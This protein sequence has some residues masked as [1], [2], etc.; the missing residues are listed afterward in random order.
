MIF[1]SKK[2]PGI[3]S[4]KFRLFAFLPTVI[5]CST[6]QLRNLIAI[7]FLTIS[8]ALKSQLL[9]TT[10][11]WTKADTEKFMDDWM[12][13]LTNDGNIHDFI[14][15]DSNSVLSY[16]LIDDNIG[17]VYRFQFGITKTQKFIDPS[18]PICIIQEYQSLCTVCGNMIK[19]KYFESRKFKFRSCENSRWLSNHLHKTLLIDRSDTLT[20]LKFEYQDIPKKE[21]KRMYS[22]CD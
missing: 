21:F 16:Q 3:K 18:T 8:I 14:K 7:F 1:R 19:R 15:K 12:E 6:V 11:S 10:G 5:S 17:A 9:F 22:N 13:E 2:L 20:H 4:K